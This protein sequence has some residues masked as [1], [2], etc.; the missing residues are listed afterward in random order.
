MSSR[1]F[2]LICTDIDGTLLNTE[3]QLSE[4]TKAA[5][6]EVPNSIPVILASSRMPAAMRHLQEELNR[7]HDPLICY[8]GGYIVSY[9]GD[10][11]PREIASVTIP[12]AVVR[13]ICDLSLPGIHISLYHKDEWFAPDWD[14]WAEREARITKVSPV[15]RPNDLV[16]AEWS[17]EN[18][19]AHKVMCM[20]P[21]DEIDR[22]ETRLQERFAADIHIY[23]S[24]P[25]YLELAPAAMSK[26][27]GLELL[28]A[29][30]YAFTMGEVIAFGD[31]YNDV[32]LLK[33]S[34]HG[35]A[36]A[37]SRESVLAIADEVAGDSRE[38]G[39]AAVIRKYFMSSPG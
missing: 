3:K 33:R 39:V 38:D 27:S 21:E 19:G 22:L 32:D 20:G 17:V 13:G 8:N 12:L 35:V 34:G 9:T 7:L 26:G 14:Y 6:R 2:S 37:N 25:T 24:R 28:I 10:G 18:K 1:R 29:R 23:R 36:V 5:F 16:V 4:E 15:I 30:E 11:V 31:N